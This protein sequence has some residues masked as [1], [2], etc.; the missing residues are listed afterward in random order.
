MLYIGNFDIKELLYMKT[1][2]ICNTILAM[3][4]MVYIA[5]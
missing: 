5:V 3:I 2:H 4:N 1:I